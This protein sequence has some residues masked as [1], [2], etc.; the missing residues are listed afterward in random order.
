MP[1]EVA[2][3]VSNPR[4]VMCR[5]EVVVPASYEHGDQI[6]CGECDTA[7]KV[8]RG[9]RVRLVLAD[10]S[11]LR[12]EVRAAQRRVQQVEEEL[13]DARHS[14]GVGINGLGVGLVYILWQIGLRDA[15]WSVP[16]L[17]QAG[18][19]SLVAGLLL[20]VANYRF[21]AKRQHLTRLAQELSAAQRELTGLRQRLRDATRA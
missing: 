16:L 1:S 9:E 6:K 14:M 20:E 4:C 10:A 7:H 21:L 2:A 3:R 11:G 15:P 5:A 8:V 12:D 19:L 18:F 17:W 13:R